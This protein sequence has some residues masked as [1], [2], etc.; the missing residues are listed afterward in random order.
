MGEDAGSGP[1]PSGR[2]SEPHEAWDPG[3]LTGLEASARALNRT[4]DTLSG[5]ELA[6]PSL[7]PGWTRAHVVAHVALNGHALAEVLDGVAHGQQVAMYPS[8]EQRDADIEKLAAVQP[9]D[10]RDQLYAATTAFADAVQVMEP[11]H[12]D[13]WFDRTPDGP[14]MPVVDIVA[15]RRREIEVHHADLGTSYTAA[16]WPEDFVLELLDAVSVDQATSGPFRVRATD[17][18]R[19]WQVGDSDGPLVLGPGW[20]LGW[21]LTGRG[22]P[23]VVTCEAGALPTLGPWRRATAARRPTP[24]Q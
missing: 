24:E 7:L 5:D 21:W 18:G 17:L 14:S 4:V 16:D 8:N 1:P 23:D 9:E 19:T 11:E 13:A 3:D 10:L 20:A 2:A 15:T 22:A 6:E 12:W